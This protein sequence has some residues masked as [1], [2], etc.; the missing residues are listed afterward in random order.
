MTNI[1]EDNTNIKISWQ[2]SWHNFNSKLPNY[3]NFVRSTNDPL[4]CNVFTL[5]PKLCLPWNY[6]E[7]NGDIWE[8]SSIW[9]HCANQANGAVHTQS[10]IDDVCDVINDI[11][12]NISSVQYTLLVNPDGMFYDKNRLCGD[13]HVTKNGKKYT[14]SVR[15][16][17]RKGSKILL[18]IVW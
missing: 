18:A 9:V 1:S 17:E 4:W 10:I 7:Y 15:R 8:C 14:F 11:N 16:G 12:Q 6:Y 2:I 3:N 13:H 5:S